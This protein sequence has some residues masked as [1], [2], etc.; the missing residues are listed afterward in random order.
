M[1]DKNYFFVD[2]PL[3]RYSISPRQDLKPNADGSVTLYIQNAVA[4][5]GQG[6]R[7]GCRRRRTSSS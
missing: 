2:N 5:G 4:G 7:T 3:N 6:K 1:Y